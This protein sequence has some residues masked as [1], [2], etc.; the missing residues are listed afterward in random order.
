[1]KVCIVE[2]GAKKAVSFH[3]LSAGVYLCPHCSHPPP[4]KTKLRPWLVAL[5]LLWQAGQGRADSLVYLAMVVLIGLVNRIFHKRSD[6]LEQFLFCTSRG[7]CLFHPLKGDFCVARLQQPNSFLSASTLCF[8]VFSVNALV[9]RR[10]LP[11]SFAFV[12]HSCSLSSVWRGLNT[13]L[14]VVSNIIITV[15]MI[16]PSILSVPSTVHVLLQELTLQEPFSAWCFTS[17]PLN[18]FI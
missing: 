8:W 10:H 17:N 16:K 9:P 3:V 13:A 7:M 4:A 1:M 6:G 18:D 15:R 5:Q 2:S 12:S 14:V 11:L